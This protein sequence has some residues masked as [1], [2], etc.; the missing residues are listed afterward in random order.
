MDIEA[1][2]DASLKLFVGAG[3]EPV[4]K[5]TWVTTAKSLGIWRLS[6]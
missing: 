6:P 5:G 4:S 3:G 2:L 1:D